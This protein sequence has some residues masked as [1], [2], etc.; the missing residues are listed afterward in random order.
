[1]RIAFVVLVLSMLALLPLDAAAKG[2]LAVKPT[3]LPDLVLG[4]DDAGFGVSQNQYALE[5]GK[6]YR[7]K[8][9]STGKK[10]YAMVAPELFSAIWVRKVEAGKVEI[11]AG[12]LYELEF[13]REAT[14]E[15]FFVPIRPG[16]Y[17]MRAK[18]LE[19][20]GMVI[21]FNIQ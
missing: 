18:G 10:E 17:E 7:L 21:K 3:K 14:A 12:A 8:I 20:R 5:T 6:A 16:T 1:M 4:T 19:A 15:L 9:V 11:K 13:E 2:D